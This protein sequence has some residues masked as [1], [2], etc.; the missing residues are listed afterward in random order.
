MAA[1]DAPPDNSYLA[2]TLT[3]AT[4]TPGVLAVVNKCNSLAVVELNTR[5]N[6]EM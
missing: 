4:V 3:M 6:H 1:S 5:E 2:L